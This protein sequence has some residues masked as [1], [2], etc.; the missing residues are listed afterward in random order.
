VDRGFVVTRG[1]VLAKP[2]VVDVQRRASARA[3]RRRTTGSCNVMLG[4]SL[5]APIT[6]RLIDAQNTL[7]QLVWEGGGRRTCHVK[8]GVLL[9]RSRD[10]RDQVRIIGAVD[11]DGD[12]LLLEL[13]D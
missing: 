4:N 5:H 12:E 2:N 7:A 11:R 6:T 1:L 10:N 8:I 3:K 9:R 13:P